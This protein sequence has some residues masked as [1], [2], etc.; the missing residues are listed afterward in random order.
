MTTDAGRELPR[1]R[2]AAYGF[3]DFG[4]NLY[5]STASMFLLYYY[6]DVLLLS[7]TT[8]GL[9]FLVA[10]VWDGIS[11]PIMGYLA[12]RTRTRWGSYRPYLLFG[13]P[14]LAVTMVLMFYRPAYESTALVVY[15]A[16]THVLFRT[17]YTVMSIPYSSLSAR[18]TRSSAVRNELSAW[19]MVSATSGGFLVAFAT[20]RLV[21]Y[22]GQGD[23]AAGFFWTAIC[24]AALSLPIYLFLFFTT[25]EPTSPSASSVN[26]NAIGLLDALGALFRN[27]AFMLVCLA[28]ALLFMGGVM[29][30]KTLIYYYKYTLGDEAA[31]GTALALMTGGAAILIP[32]WAWL[33]TRLE[34]RTV[35]L[36]GLAISLAVSIAIYVNPLETVPVV[37]LLFALGAAGTAASYLSFW[38]ML[39]DTVEYGEWQTGKRVESL[40]FGLMSFVQKVSFGFAA[41]ILGFLLDWI[42]YVPNAEQGASTL[43]SI[44]VIMTLLPAGFLA[45]AIALL[46]FYPLTSSRHRE[47]VAELDAV[48]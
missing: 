5:W 47:I 17:F 4:F 19:R 34:K 43:L 15:A 29:T 45:G 12:E 27:R 48:R 46:W 35:W 25:Q 36:S 41:A 16:A 32:V 40:S 6:T 2:R 3:G 26:E 21:E 44:K 37:T 39:P 42:G 30:S 28:T 18:I 11:D 10:M 14:A 8:A 13:G 33:A 23:L 38:S 31:S 20:L 7:A 24:F 22:F 1:W 9:I